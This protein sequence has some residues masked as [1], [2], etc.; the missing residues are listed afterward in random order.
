MMFVSLI[1]Y[2]LSAKKTLLSNVTVAS[3]SRSFTDK[4][5]SSNNMS[6]TQKHTVPIIQENEIDSELAV[7][8]QDTEDTE[9]N[10]EPP[11]KKK[12]SLEMMISNSQVL[13]EHVNKCTPAMARLKSSSTCTTP[14]ASNS[15]IENLKTPD[16]PYGQIFYDHP[17]T[18]DT[19]KKWKKYV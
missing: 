1:I 16:T 11:L 5:N 3:S 4:R 19:K 13:G 2:F 18:A 15:F 10:V 12:C 7:P 9:D 17:V 6:F 8:L 14:V